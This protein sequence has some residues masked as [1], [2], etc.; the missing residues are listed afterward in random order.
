MCKMENIRVLGVQH[1]RKIF[2]VLTTILG[3]TPKRERSNR[4][5]GLAFSTRVFEARKLISKVTRQ[6]GRSA[7]AT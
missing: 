7:Y 1:R 2:H 5:E 6:N 3:E 4:V